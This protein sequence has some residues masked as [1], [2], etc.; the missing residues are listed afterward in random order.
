MDPKL[1]DTAILHPDGLLHDAYESALSSQCYRQICRGSFVS[2]F[3]NYNKNVNVAL[4][5]C[6]K[7]AS[8][9]F[10]S[11]STILKVEKDPTICLSLSCTLV[12]RLSLQPV[13]SV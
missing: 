4:D 12:H 13:N 3:I 9:P 10:L 5:A 11:Y 6:N 8:R 1:S 2:C 7:L